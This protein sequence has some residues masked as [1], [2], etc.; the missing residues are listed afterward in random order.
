MINLS[1]FEYYNNLYLEYINLLIDEIY[2]CYGEKKVN[3]L[4]NQDYS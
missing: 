1:D 3:I 4:F 2:E